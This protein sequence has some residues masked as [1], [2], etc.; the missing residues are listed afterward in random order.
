MLGF[1]Q[2]INFLINLSFIYN[3]DTHNI[4]VN[5]LSAIKVLIFV[6][7]SKQHTKL[8]LTHN[9]TLVSVDTTLRHL[10]FT[11]TNRTPGVK[12]Y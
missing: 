11:G 2:R 8:N 7:F 12:E 4:E 10:G 6:A 1:H 5:L 9:Q 3:S